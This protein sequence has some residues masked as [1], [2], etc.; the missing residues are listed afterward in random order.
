VTD[1]QGEV[2][3][4]TRELNEALSREAATSEVLGV[5]SSSPNDL[6]PVFD[7]ILEKAVRICAGVC[8]SSWARIVDDALGRQLSREPFR[9]PRIY[10]LSGEQ[11]TGDPM[12][13]V[14]SCLIGLRIAASSSDQDRR[15][16]V[17]RHIDEYLRAV[18]FT[19][20]DAL[21]RLPKQGDPA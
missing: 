11:T 19:L 15:I 6:Q 21:E 5:I 4:V 17:E 14:Q 1:L 7:T 16:V 2:A 9:P 20:S 10:S 12:D 13:G 8:K 3:W 18:P